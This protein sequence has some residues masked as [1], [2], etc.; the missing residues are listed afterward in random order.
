MCVNGIREG[1]AFD[2]SGQ[3]VPY[4]WRKMRLINC[5]RKVGVDI[6]HEMFN[7]QANKGYYGPIVAFGPRG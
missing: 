3:Y 2:D 1:G 6:V 5:E 4:I 7:S